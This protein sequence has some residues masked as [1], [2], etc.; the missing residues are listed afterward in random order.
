MFGEDCAALASAADVSCLEISSRMSISQE[1]WS[2]ITK[3]HTSLSS[4]LRVFL[5]SRRMVVVYTT[6]HPLVGE[7][8]DRERLFI[9]GIYFTTYA[10]IIGSCCETF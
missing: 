9:F 5:M 2:V 1:T 8:N 3:V 6:D 10:K 4:L 7:W